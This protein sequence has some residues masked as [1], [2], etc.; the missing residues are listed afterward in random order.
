M[1]AVGEVPLAADGGFFLHHRPTLGVIEVIEA[2]VTGYGDS[3]VTVTVHSI[4]L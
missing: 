3:G 2:G 1:I 4:A